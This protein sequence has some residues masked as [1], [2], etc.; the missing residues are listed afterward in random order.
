MTSNPYATNPYAT[1]PQYAPVVPSPISVPP[2]QFAKPKRKT[3]VLTQV[4]ALIGLAVGFLTATY[5]TAE[6]MASDFES[7]KAIGHVCGQVIISMLLGGFSGMLLWQLIKH[8][9]RTLVLAGAFVGGVTAFATWMHGS[10]IPHR[11]SPFVDVTRHQGAGRV[12]ADGSFSF[13][14][15][16]GW[17][18]DPSDKKTL[19][20]I[21]PVQAAFATNLGLYVYPTKKVYLTAQAVESQARKTLPKNAKLQSV[22]HLTVDGKETFVISSLVQDSGQSIWHTQYIMAGEN[23][24][25]R[26]ATCGSVPEPKDVQ[27]V[28][29]DVVNSIRFD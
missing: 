7:G 15:P 25:Y 14:P 1:L 5:P 22:G 17:Q 12:K 23:H 2:Q 24:L 21:G 19:R 28:L 9:I 20:Y 29:Q 3:N 27:R 6:Q 26:L 18:R 8:P 16:A 11:A 4:G 10:P 13:V